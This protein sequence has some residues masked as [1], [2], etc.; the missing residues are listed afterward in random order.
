[1]P[2][3]F[4]EID[5]HHTVQRVIVAKSKEW[6]EQRLGGTW[7]ETADPYSTEPQAV[8]YCGIGFGHDDTFP[9]RFAQ[10][11]VMPAPDP[12]TGEWSSYSKG[13]VRFHDGHLWKSTVDGNVWEPGVSAWHP[14]PDIEGVGPNWIMPTGAHDAYSI[15]DQ[16]THDN[17]NDGGSIWVYESTIDG[18]TTEPGRDGTFDRWWTPIQ[19]A[20]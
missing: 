17:P 6:C 1:M 15:G 4:A 16:R 10:P 13:E 2:R 3:Y 19:V 5:S 9:E 8:I 18:N 11:W 12:E 7:V 20:Q 14:E